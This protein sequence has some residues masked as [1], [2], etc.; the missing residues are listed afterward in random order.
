[1]DKKVKIARRLGFITHKKG[2][3]VSPK[4][5]RNLKD[6]EKMYIIAGGY[7]QAGSALYRAALKDHKLVTVEKD[8][9]VIFSAD[10]APPGTK[11]S[12]D[13]L[14]DRLFEAG[15]RVHYY[16]TQENLHV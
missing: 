12:V 8:D 3:I 2:L 15:A 1:I 7:G 13:Y 4:T 5:I 9:M 16:D 10:P 14:V 11:E 6:S